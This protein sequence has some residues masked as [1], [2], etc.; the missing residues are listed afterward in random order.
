MPR[1]MLFL[2]LAGSLPGYCGAQMLPIFGPKQYTRA[3][4]KPQTLTD[5]FLNCE[6]AAQYQM[7]V[8]NGNPN[9]TNRVS[10]ATILLNGTEVV[11]P[12]DLNQ[13]VA[14]V[15]K[16]VAVVG[17][18]TLTTTLKSAPGS[19]LTIDVQ[20]TSNCLSVQ[21]SSPTS[22]ATLMQA[23]AN[24][25][26]TVTSSADEVGVVVN[27]LGAFVQRGEFATSGVPLVLGT[28]VLTATATNACLNQATA[29]IQVNATAL[30]PPLITLVATPSSGLAPLNVT[31]SA[32]VS[33][34][35]PITL[36]QWDFNGNGVIDVSG[37]S[38]SQVSNTYSQPGLFIATVTATDS[39]GNQYSQ[40]TPVLVLS[41]SALTTLMQT[42]WSSLVSALQSQNLTSASSLFDPS[43][44]Q[45]F[46]TVFTNLGS[47]LPQ[48][49]SS[50]GNVG[51]FSVSDGV[52][53][54]I[55]VRSQQGSEFVYFIYA[56]QDQ[57]GLWKFLAM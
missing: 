41:P 6:K 19:L 2:L 18:N 33:S 34:A 1:V 16:P 22:G 28:N 36:Y 30:N 39:L 17:T 40:Q 23:T 31:F 9:G 10:S 44:A 43:V 37:A 13:N 50:L 5:T 38:L 48:I 55:T 51:V 7:V 52:T 47:Q 26:G 25:S 4:G 54:L 49:A 27:G 24:V 45:K 29:T 35:N 3:T 15:M 12:S 57:N 42:R 11:G 53:E 46:Q 14:E 56:G 21:I 8:T 20:C 32:T